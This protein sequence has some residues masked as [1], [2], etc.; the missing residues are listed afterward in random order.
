[1]GLVCPD[2]VMG[3]DSFNDW[4]L[5]VGSITWRDFDALV[6]FTNTRSICLSHTA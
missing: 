5:G 1:M 3:G 4:V 6:C 2:R